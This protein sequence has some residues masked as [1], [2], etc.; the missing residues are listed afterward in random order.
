MCASAVFIAAVVK[1]VAC[2]LLFAP[3]ETPPGVVER[4]GAFL[5]NSPDGLS[6]V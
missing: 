4:R 3:L 6:A 1:L 2:I 5:S